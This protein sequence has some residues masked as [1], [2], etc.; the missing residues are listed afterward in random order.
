MGRT[1]YQQLALRP[2]D[3][4]AA[5]ALLA[6]WLG[7]DPSL[8]G[9]AERIRERTGGNPFF[10]EE[11]IQ[12]EIDAGT[13][14]GTRGRFRLARPVASIVV[15]A[16]V[17]SLLA[18]R[19]DRLDEGTKRLL[20]TAAVLGDGF[21]EPLLAR[22]A[23]SAPE[24]LRGRLR[25]LVQG[26]FLYE[27]SLYPELEYAFKHPLTR[28]VAYG[29]LLRERRRELHARTAEAIEER[30]GAAADA[31]A[32]VIAHHFEEADRLVDA[33]RWHVRA[34]ERLGSAGVRETLFHWRKV[35]ELLA[36]ETGSPEAQVLLGRA[37]A[38]L[39]YAASRSELPEEEIAALFEAALGATPEGDSIPRAQLFLVY[40]LARS[41]AGHRAESLRLFDEALATTRRLGNRDLLAEALWVGSLVTA[42][43]E[44]PER[45]VELVRE[46]EAVCSEDP[47]IGGALIGGRPL[48]FGRYQ[49]YRALVALGRAP[50]AESLLIWLRGIVT[51]SV[52]PLE[53]SVLHS[54]VSNWLARSGN[55]D[56]AL[57]EARRSFEQSQWTSNP[58]SRGGA[59]AALGFALARAARHAE[60]EREFEESIRI[61]LDGRTIAIVGAQHLSRLGLLR[62]ARGDLAGAREAIRRG[63]DF[64]LAHG[65]GG[66]EAANRAALAHVL[67]VEGGAGALA[68]ARVE[69]DRAEALCRERSVASTLALVEEARAEVAA[70]EADGAAREQ[71]LREAARLHRACGDTWAAE[72]A[73]ARIPATSAL[74]HRFGA[75]TPSEKL[76]REDRRR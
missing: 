42:A 48:V 5:T 27:Q 66:T 74:R 62:L 61:A 14:V 49:C 22:V 58:L 52:D 71:A 3:A 56:G 9:L 59:H 68:A 37:R 67:V 2:L 35:T 26:E 38:G 7:P 55:V 29:S 16:S 32:A 76:L 75:P 65:L 40:A 24:A 44:D 69:I 51:E 6:D 53:R 54:C 20:Q 73:E 19:I 57:E 64:A 25:A 72:Q 63:L 41:G 31:Q 10:M 50:E 30:A 60:A 28:E 43:D 12:A 70:L 46:L 1:H 8:A 36:G 45:T 17:Q 21:A 11:V 15:P 34:A 33:A 23:C 47:S 18:A 4:A 39:V 13:L